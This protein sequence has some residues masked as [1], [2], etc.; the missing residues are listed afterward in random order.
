MLLWPIRWRTPRAAIDLGDRL[1]SRGD[2]D[3]ALRAFQRAMDSN[4]YHC[5]P[6]GAWWMA[7]LLKRQGDRDAAQACYQ[8]AI[9]SRHEAWAPRAA[10]DLADML[11]EQGHTAMACSYYQLAITYGDPANPDSIW[12]RRAQE[13][14]DALL[15]RPDD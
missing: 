2:L 13:R 9:D 1:S 7:N 14:L 3:G 4:D 5:R 15:A 12:A 8:R 6:G 11:I 10:T